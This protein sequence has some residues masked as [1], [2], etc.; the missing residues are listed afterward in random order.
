[1]SQIFPKDKSTDNSLLAVPQSAVF[2][3]EGDTSVFVAKPDEKNTF[4][5]R[6]ILAGPCVD[7]YIPI[8]SG[9]REGEQ[10]VVHGGFILKAELGKEGV[11]HEH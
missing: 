3:V 6:R 8:L 1:M 7:E 4:Q 5:K 11:A 2:T 9:L 10:V